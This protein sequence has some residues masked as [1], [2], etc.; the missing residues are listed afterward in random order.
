LKQN[1][2]IFF[3]ALFSAF[4]GAFIAM[5][6]QKPAQIILNNEIPAQFS[7][8]SESLL[9]GNVNRK[10][11]ATPYTSMIS[12]SKKATQS[13]V[14]IK[15]LFGGGDFSFWT[16]STPISISNGSGV[17]ISPD[18]YI[19]TNRHVVNGSTDIEITTNDKHTYKAELIGSDATTDIALLKIKPKQSISFL[20]FG[21]SDSI[22]VG[23][24]V[25]AVGNPFNLE[26]TVTAGIVSAK[27]RSL[28]ILEDTY[29]IESFIQTDA[30]V[31]PGNSGGA[32]VNGAGELIGINTAIITKSGKY[33]GYSFSIPSNLVLKTIQDLKKYGFAQ[34][35]ILGAKIDNIS[36]IDMEIN[37]L[38]NQNGVVILSVTK[39]S[40]AAI[41][42]LE[43]GDILIAI[44]GKKFNSRPEFQEILGAYKPGN[45]IS[46]D[47]IRNGEYKNT[48]TVLRNKE[49][50][51]DVIEKPSMAVA[52]KLGFK[53]RDQDKEELAKFGHKGVIVTYV[54]SNSK[55][56]RVNLTT[57]FCITK[58]NDQTFENLDEFL[59]IL[60][61]QKGKV[62]LEG[63]YENYSEPFYYAFDMKN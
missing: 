23:E 11:I 58:I 22:Q 42:G 43:K 18:G 47:F 20:Y 32:L 2:I 29:A 4:I 1:I 9:N 53:L 41:S 35:A 38:K 48:H 15:S 61:A 59:L 60:N 39:N 31:N 57:G 25:L 37:H 6:F 54:K 27:A 30:V 24:A 45:L 5:Y 52:E 46:I 17:I 36:P 34:R 26:S 56:S 14:N 50:N 19:V 13:V 7:S 10:N 62:V 8:Y 40:A 63:K 21:N 3:V 12:A 33:E 51:I 28:N 49:N 16:H 44:D 55:I